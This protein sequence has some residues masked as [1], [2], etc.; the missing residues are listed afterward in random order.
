MYGFLQVTAHLNRPKVLEVKRSVFSFCCYK[1]TKKTDPTLHLSAPE[2]GE[3]NAERAGLVQNLKTSI[4]LALHMYLGRN[5]F[6][7]SLQA[8]EYL[9][10]L[11]HFDQSETFY[12]HQE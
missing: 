7:L 2:E 1:P 9:Q 4:Q 6:Q 8:Q 12:L 5:N 3:E 11:E 10:C